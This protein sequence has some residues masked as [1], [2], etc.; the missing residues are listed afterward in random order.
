MGELF[1]REQCEK[2]F[3]EEV[4]RAGGSKKWLRKH[5][6]YGLDHVYHMIDNGSYFHH[7]RVMEVLG[8]KAV[9]RWEAPNDLE[10]ANEPQE[11]LKL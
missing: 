5:K 2:Y 7:P 8:F 4:K 6:V 1:T 10:A 3:R 11:G 9:E